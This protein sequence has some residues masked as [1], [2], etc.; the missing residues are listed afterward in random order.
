MLVRSLLSEVV[1]VASCL[2]AGWKGGG[3]VCWPEI[4]ILDEEI[5]RL[6]DPP[7]RT[8]ARSFAGPLRVASIRSVGK[9]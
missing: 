1:L 3:T 6:P 7:P 9:L 8:G 4:G 5:G 2:V